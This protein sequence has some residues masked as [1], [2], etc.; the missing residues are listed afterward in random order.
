MNKYYQLIIDCFTKKYFQFKKRASRK[1]YLSFVVFS[2]I[3]DLLIKLLFFFSYTG[4][5]VISSLYLFFIFIPSLTVTVRRL[6]DFNLK[7]YWSLI[8]I[9]IS[10]CL[11]IEKYKNISLIAGLI[12]ILFTLSLIFIKGTPNTNKYGEPPIN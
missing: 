12:L 9:P 3:C 2:I 11:T 4:F 5:T 7:G 8:I 10:C 6:H 1:E